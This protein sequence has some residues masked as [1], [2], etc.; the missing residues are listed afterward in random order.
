MNKNIS[1]LGEVFLEMW[2]FSIL[3]SRMQEMKKR[4][5][6]KRKRKMSKRKRKKQPNALE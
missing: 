1:S 4:K 3:G 5:M 2:D 6:S